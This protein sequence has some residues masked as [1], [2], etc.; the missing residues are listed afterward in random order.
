MKQATAEDRKAANRA[1]QT[2]QGLESATGLEP[3]SYAK[4]LRALGQALEQHRFSFLDLEIQGGFTSS[5][6]R[7]PP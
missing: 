6:G 3:F 5:E 1:V 2:S 7:P 4:E